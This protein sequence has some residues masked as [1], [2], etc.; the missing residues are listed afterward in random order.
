[1]AIIYSY[2][3]L[4]PQLGDKVLGSN[5]VDA[6][7]AAVTGN[8]TVQYTF[9]DIKTLVDQQFI[10]QF[11]S[12]SN[13]SLVA[14]IPA[15][16]GPTATNTAH[17][18]IFGLA[19][20]TSTSVTIDAAGKVTWLKTGT[21]YVTQE[22]YLSGTN[23]ANILYTLFRTY[24][25]TSQIGPTHAEIFNVDNTA[26]TRRVVINQMIN[27]T[28]DQVNSYHVYQMVRDSNGANDGKLYQK[29][30]NNSWTSTPNAQITISKLI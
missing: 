1:M 16:Q 8:P 15:N 23:T 11:T 10:E 20:S 4:T 29:L 14:G 30:N 25:G 2:P 17:Q 5:I 22:Y 28:T 3:T 21:Y 12:S 19:N 18:I 7:G 9:T 13:D 24:D 26:K 27:I 6:S